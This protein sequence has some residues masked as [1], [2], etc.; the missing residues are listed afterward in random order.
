V[1]SPVKGALRALPDEEA[2][3]EDVEEDAKAA[4]QHHQHTLH[5]VRELL[6]IANRLYSKGLSREMDLAFDD[7]YG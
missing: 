3:G 4:H 7:M 1:S 2:D 5:Q 6:Q